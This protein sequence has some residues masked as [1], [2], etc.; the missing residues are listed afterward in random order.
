MHNRFKA[1]V[2]V[3]GSAAFVLVAL[4]LRVTFKP[5]PP[6]APAPVVTQAAVPLPVTITKQNFGGFTLKINTRGNPSGTEYAVFESAS[7]EWVDP[8]A[9][10]ISSPAPVWAADKG[11]WDA[12][13]SGVTFTNLSPNKAYTFFA[14]ARN[15]LKEET[16]FGPATLGFTVPS[17]DEPAAPTAGRIVTETPVNANVNKNANANANSNSNTNA[18]VALGMLLPGRPA[19]FRLNP[20]ELLLV[21]DAGG[22]TTST[23]FAVQDAVSGKYVQTDG[24]L[25][26]APVFRIFLDWG[27]DSG[28]VVRTEPNRNYRFQV[29][30]KPQDQ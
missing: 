10:T 4:N 14:K 20:K 22:N 13:R 3:A 26:A 25:G 7:G 27:G 9:K 11:A 21:I 28:F 16:A 2:I 24:T 8:V 19:V 12:L 1:G 15:S 5:T 23:T 29:M 18:A 6:G 17:A 30:A